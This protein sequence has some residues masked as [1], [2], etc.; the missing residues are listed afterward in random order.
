MANPM[1][2]GA[3][4]GLGKYLLED[5]P[6]HR[7]NALMQAEI[8]KFSPLTGRQGQAV[9]PP[10]M[11]GALAQGAAMGGMMGQQFG[12]AGGSG[13]SMYSQAASPGMVDGPQGLAP[14]MAINYPPQQGSMFAQNPQMMA[15]EL[16]MASELDQLIRNQIADQ[17]QQIAAQKEQLVQMQNR[18]KQTDL[19]PLMAIA[20]AWGGGKTNLA[21]AYQSMKPRNDQA[22]L[23]A[24]SQQLMQQE[25]GLTGKYMDLLRMQESKKEKQARL[26]AKKLD[27]IAKE[28]KPKK[29]GDAEWKSATFASRMDQAEKEMAKLADEGYRRQDYEESIMAKLGFEPAKDENL[30]RQEQAERNFL[31][32]VLRKES[33]AVIS[34]EEFKSGALQYFPRVGDTDK[35]LSQKK[36]NRDLAITAMAASGGGAFDQV[37]K[38]FNE[39]KEKTYTDTD[40][41]VYKQVGDE[42]IEQ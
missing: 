30:K 16:L 13:G 28:N 14:G 4:A 42:W 37:Q 18:P 33:G 21:Q 27:K 20:D 1:M 26:E 23:Q 40:G 19:T 7:Q 15:Q 31:N 24:L 25:Q 12:G 35:V 9:A 29:F 36:A 17:Q 5:L 32:A 10:S 39:K 11:F 22:K 41:T 2:I 6:Q 34:P 38:K 8:Q 3:A